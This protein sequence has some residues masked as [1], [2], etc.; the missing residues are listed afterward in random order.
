MA[1]SEFNK[2]DCVSVGGCHVCLCLVWG[3]EYA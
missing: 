1:I 3:S 2:L